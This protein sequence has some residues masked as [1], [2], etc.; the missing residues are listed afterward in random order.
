M[1]AALTFACSLGVQKTS[2]PVPTD[3]PTP[4]EEGELT[5][6]EIEATVASAISVETSG[7]SFTISMTEEQILS[8]ANTNLA[9]DS[10]INVQN[11]QV[12]LQNGVIE[13]SGQVKQVITLDVH[14][15]ARPVLD[16]AGGVSVE[17]VSV[18]FGGMTA[19]DS[20]KE[21]ISTTLND[22]INSQLSKIGD[23][24]V[25]ESIEIADGKITV[26][27]QKR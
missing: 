12:S 4:T 19:P 21:S 20:I 18:D 9:S 13:L 14:V 27:G 17:L 22:A 1:L 25:I 16:D 7:N 10:G 15:V 5:A 26:T 24:V 8:L 3:T 11:L 6:P 23:Q 2:T